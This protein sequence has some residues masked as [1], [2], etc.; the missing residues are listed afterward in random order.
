VWAKALKVDTAEFVR[1]LMR[2]YDPITHEILFGEAREAE[3]NRN[4]A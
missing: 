2:Y 3:R 4:E 1:T